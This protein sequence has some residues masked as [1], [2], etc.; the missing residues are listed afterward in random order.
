M[1]YVVDRSWSHVASLSFLLSLLG[2]EQYRNED[3][4]PSCA[5]SVSWIRLAKDEGHGSDFVLSFHSKPVGKVVLITYEH[6]A[7]ITTMSPS[8]AFRTNVRVTGTS[9]H[10]SEN[11][12]TSFWLFFSPRQKSIL[13]FKRLSRDPTAYRVPYW[14]WW[15]REKTK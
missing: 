1:S 3:F 6:L 13:A 11:I 12:K 4:H 2:W 9:Q 7:I 15:R 14:S 5:G 8:C 10:I